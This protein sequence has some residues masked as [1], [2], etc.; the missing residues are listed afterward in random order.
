MRM[1]SLI[2]NAYLDQTNLWTLFLRFRAGQTSLSLASLNIVNLWRL[3]L[4]L[5]SYCTCDR[6]SAHC[7]EMYSQPGLGPK[8]LVRFAGLICCF[9]I[10]G[11]VCCL[12][13]GLF[14]CA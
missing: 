14:S 6:N 11:G 9:E 13:I 5:T 8:P 3:P 12:C 7:G 1:E 4:I 2:F 10:G